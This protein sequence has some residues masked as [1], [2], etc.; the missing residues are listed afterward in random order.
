VANW[1][2]DALIRTKLTAA[3]PDTKIGGYWDD[4]AAI[5]KLSFDF[6]PEFDRFKA[7]KKQMLPME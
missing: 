6:R 5:R 2:A 3:I 1:S 7:W 4:L